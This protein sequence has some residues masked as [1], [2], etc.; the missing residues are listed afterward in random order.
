MAVLF[1]L[2]SGEHK[3]DVVRGELH[4]FGHC[5]RQLWQ[6]G[7]GLE[8]ECKGAKFVCFDCSAQESVL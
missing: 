4:V 7:G 6:E 5:W 1:N 3:S 8:I 2:R